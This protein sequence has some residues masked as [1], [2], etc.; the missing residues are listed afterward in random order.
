MA[1]ISNR[2]NL[3]PRYNWDY[4]LTDLE[5]TIRAAFHRKL[6]DHSKLSGIFGM[7]P[8]FTT[9]GRA[10]LYA[11]LKSL[12]LPGGSGVGVPLF[13]CPVVFETIKT[14]GL[15]PIFIDIDLDTYNLAPHDLRKKCATLAAVIAV[16]MFGHPSDIDE[17]APA[18]GRT[19]PVIE[20]C[21]QSLFSTY[22]GILSGSRTLV[23]FF[24]FR[25]GKYI[26]AGE[27]SAIFC[28]DPS[29]RESL[30]RTLET[31]TKWPLH[32]EMSHCFA[33]YIKSLLYHRP[34]YGLIGRP[35]GTILDKKMNLTA[36]IGVELRKISKSDYCIIND[37]IGDFPDRVEEQRKRAFYLLE[38]IRLNKVVLPTERPECRSNYYQFAIRFTT[39][40]AR[41]NAA[42]RLADQGI[43]SA[44]YLDDVVED[45]TRVYGYDGGC[46]NAE[47]C[48]KTV[49]VVP[50][51]Y[52]LS[53][54]DM[55]RIANAINNID[56]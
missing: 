1:S 56:Q 35:I 12:N 24:S 23:S 13:C 22:K 28:T 32:Q 15:K 26:S 2:I 21:A 53:I 14:S 16:D 31:F 30:Q 17:I 6:Q 10:S 19:I 39:A 27:G 37:R 47:L 51:Y 25:S 41:D 55:D 43:D 42:L 49:L 9:S 48:S 18:C 11:I 46:P 5:K 33:T 29:L 36:K 7:E 44:K 52:T 4:S 20:D 38:R 45:A 50:N 8:L 34:W 40:E 3:I 54:A